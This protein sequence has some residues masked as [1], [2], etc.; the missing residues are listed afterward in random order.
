M[1]KETKIKIIFGIIFI[2]LCFM[3]LSVI[4]NKD[5]DQISSLHSIAKNAIAQEEFPGP[6]WCWSCRGC[7]LGYGYYGYLVTCETC[8]Y[9]DCYTMP[10]YYGLC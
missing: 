9:T 8:I 3:N 10:C 5:N 7:Y 4:L 2:F 6:F 1:A